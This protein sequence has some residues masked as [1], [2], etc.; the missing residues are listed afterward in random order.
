MRDQLGLIASAAELDELAAT[1][2]DTGGVYI[3][4]AFSGL[5]AP[6]WREDARGLITGLTRYAS[7]AHICRAALEAAAYQVAD[8][9]H[10][11][12]QDSGVALRE[13]RVNG[14]MVRSDF[15][16]QFQADILSR[17]VVRPAVT[18]TTALGAAYAAG[19]AVGVWSGTDELRALWREDR[20][21]APGMG[22]AERERLF[23]G[24]HTAVRR[25][26]SAPTS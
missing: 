2:P 18:E 11:M 26:F 25:S 21:W 4:P 23:A 9:A 8:V 19:L 13:L 10:A 5:Y 7:K 24:W 17:P 16:L 12:V 1:V 14:G 20:R 3:V 15:L 6:W 22:A